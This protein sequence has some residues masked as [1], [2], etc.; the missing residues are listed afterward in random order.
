MEVR[1]REQKELQK[2]DCKK[3]LRR[4]L[5]CTGV[6]ANSEGMPKKGMPFCAFCGFCENGLTFYIPF[7]T[8]RI[9]SI[10]ITDKSENG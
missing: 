6:T 4:N 5:R 9:E 1:L 3:R 2:R 10:R 7:G 8:I